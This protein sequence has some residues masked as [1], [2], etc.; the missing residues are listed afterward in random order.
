MAHQ[1]PQARTKKPAAPKVVPDADNAS[2]PVATPHNVCVRFIKADAPFPAGHLLFCT[3]E[4][5]EKLVRN[6]IA[7]WE[8]FEPKAAE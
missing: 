3:Q 2:A 1:R 8:G 7:K 4:C 5:A 6:G